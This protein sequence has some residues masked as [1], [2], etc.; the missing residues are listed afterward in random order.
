MP[1]PRSKLS[2][3]HRG[4]ALLHERLGDAGAWASSPMRKRRR[5]PVFR[6][7]V[8]SHGMSL[9]SAVPDI[10]A[11]D[12]IIKTPAEGSGRFHLGRTDAPRTTAGTSEA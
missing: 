12:C 5:N 8:S 11:E 3:D 10:A 6:A 7:F 1:P 2:G 9:S 4:N